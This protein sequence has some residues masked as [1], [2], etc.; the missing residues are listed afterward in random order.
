MI[1]P[2]TPEAILAE[3]TAQLWSLHDATAALVQAAEL[4]AKALA[5]L[6]E[7]ESTKI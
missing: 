2:Q 5:K 1:Q 7:D 6:A 4:Y 3:I